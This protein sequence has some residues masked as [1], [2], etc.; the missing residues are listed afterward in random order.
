MQVLDPYL[1]LSEEIPGWIRGEQAR[2][3]AL[4][5]Y[6]LPGT[7]VIVQIG[8]F[9]GSA[10]VLLAG[11]RKAKGSGRVYCVDPFDCSGDEF[12]VPHYRKILAAAGGG[13]LRDH[14]ERNLRRAG[15]DDWVTV[16]E[17]RAEEVARRW[18]EPIDMLALNGDQSPA[19]ARAAYQ[20]WSPYLKPGGTIAVHNS[21]PGPRLESHSGNRRLVE[22]EIR[23]PA[24]TDIRLVVATTFALRAL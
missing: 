1:R 12:S 6:E 18:S 15:L 11:A 7:P 14:F 17:G 8:S 16:L 10:A 20:A 9:F 3:L 23:P 2:A 21:A 24:C 19:G 5:S 13:A 22:E 4:V